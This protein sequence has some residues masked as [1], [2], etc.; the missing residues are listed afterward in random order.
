MKMEQVYIYIYS[1]NNPIVRDIVCHLMY[2]SS[3]IAH[4]ILSALLLISP[5]CVLTETS[6]RHLL[7]VGIAA[8]LLDKTWLFR[9]LARL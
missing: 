8:S 4:K 7:A 6:T 2:P 9:Q 5:A 3:M 1:K